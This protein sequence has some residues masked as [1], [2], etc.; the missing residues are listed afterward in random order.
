M[1]TSAQIIGRRPDNH[2][3]F[4]SFSTGWNNRWSHDGVAAVAHQKLSQ[5]TKDRVDALLLLNL[6]TTGLKQS[7]LA[8]LAWQTFSIK[9]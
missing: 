1:R 9:N 5:Q 3:C 8:E 6:A 4:W 7:A 2:F